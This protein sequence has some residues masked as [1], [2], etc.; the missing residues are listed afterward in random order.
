[1]IWPEAAREHPPQQRREPRQTGRRAGR[2]ALGRRSESNFH[3][4]PSIL[5]GGGTRLPR[6]RPKKDE[7]RDVPFTEEPCSAEPYKI[8]AFRFIL[9]K[10]PGSDYR[11]KVQRSTLSHMRMLHIEAADRE[12]IG[13]QI[14]H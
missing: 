10:A 13:Q 8:F 14:R 3:Q 7:K 9:I 11:G 2:G 4:V 6:H 5:T 1:M 12:Q